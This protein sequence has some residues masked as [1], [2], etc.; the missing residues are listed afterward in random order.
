MFLRKDEIVEIIVTLHSQ[1]LTI[2]VKVLFHHIFVSDIHIDV[3]G[4]WVM[5]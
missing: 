1:V 5:I 4:S 3:C 2:V